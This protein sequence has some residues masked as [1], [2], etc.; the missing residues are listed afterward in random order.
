MMSC[1]VDG[2]EREI[3]IGLGVALILPT[4]PLGIYD[5]I[6]NWIC[7]LLEE[8]GAIALMTGAIGWCPV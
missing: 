6:S 8:V 3:S 7:L 2:I 4:S 5:A 1:S